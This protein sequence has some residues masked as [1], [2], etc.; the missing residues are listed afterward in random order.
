MVNIYIYATSS[1]WSNNVLVNAMQEDK[2]KTKQ[3]LK[4]KFGVVKLSINKGIY[5]YLY[6]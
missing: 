6:Y 4:L 2:I 3:F 5:P 1:C